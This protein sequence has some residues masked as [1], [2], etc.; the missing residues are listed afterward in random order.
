M[1]FINLCN[2]Y[3]LWVWVR[4]QQLFFCG[5][6]V[7]AKQRLTETLFRHWPEQGQSSVVAVIRRHVFDGEPSWHEC[8][9][10]AQV[11]DA[12]HAG[13]PEVLEK[14]GRN[15][16]GLWLADEFPPDVLEP[17]EMDPAVQAVPRVSLRRLTR[18]A[19]RTARLAGRNGGAEL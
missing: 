19:H 16:A 12:M 17:I 8:R 2:S 11:L 7:L 6:G 10:L 4:Q 14:M 13:S 9:R 18:V 3:R 5:G 1:G 15:V